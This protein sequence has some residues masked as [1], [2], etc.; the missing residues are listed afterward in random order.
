MVQQRSGAAGGS[1][2]A[3]GGGVRL[4]AG[5][6]ASLV[7]VV[8]LA[9]FMI[10]NTDRITLTFLFWSFTWPLWLFTVVTALV[11]ALI[12]FGLGVMRRH[13]RRTDRRA[14]RRD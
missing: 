4:G 12:W 11:G 1:A 13:R 5:A 6:I 14:E 3:G 9:I 8:L 7:G 2:G 10:Q